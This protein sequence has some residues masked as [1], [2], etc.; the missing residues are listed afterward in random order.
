M[1]RVLVAA[2]FMTAFCPSVLADSKASLFEDAGVKYRAG[3]FKK[4]EALYEELSETRPTSAV[5]YNLGNASFRAGHKGRALVHYRRAQR[6]TPRDRDLLWNIAILKG[7]FIDR[8]D[9][10]DANFLL[11]SLQETADLVAVNELVWAFTAG[12][13]SLAG[14]CLLAFL[15]QPLRPGTRPVAALLILCLCAVSTFLVFKWADGKEPLAVV[16]EKEVFARYGPSEKENRAFA[17]H[18][19][20]EGR[21]LDRSRDWIYFGLPDGKTG[22]VPETSC[23]AV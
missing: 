13:A 4:A 15:F 20:A 19:G 1:R 2:L 18:E 12:A 9:R 16:V 5:Y 7:T 8:F 17:M 22:W 23:E 21:V 6:I 14:V 10:R 11:R 3:E